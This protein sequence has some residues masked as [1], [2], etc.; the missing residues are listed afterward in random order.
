MGGEVGWSGCLSVVGEDKMSPHWSLAL[1]PVSVLVLLMLMLMLML[2]SRP[3]DAVGF[4]R[5]REKQEEEGVKGEEGERRRREDREF[6]QRVGDGEARYVPRVAVG[7]RD[8]IRIVWR[9]MD[10]KGAAVTNRVT[11]VWK[12]RDQIRNRA[13]RSRVE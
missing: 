8:E 3:C 1:V 11:R 5:A 10:A 4:A 12:Q 7:K 13:E 2:A 9:G 6:C